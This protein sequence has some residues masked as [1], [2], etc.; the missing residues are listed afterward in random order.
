MKSCLFR[1][2]ITPFKKLT[3]ERPFALVGWSSSLEM[4]HYDQELAKDFIKYYAKSGPER[5]F[6]D[7]QYKHLLI[8][9]AKVV[10]N[11]IDSTVCPSL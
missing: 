7:G 6:R 1:H 3:V 4:S 11:V 8:E 5:M 2:I 10:T 9:K